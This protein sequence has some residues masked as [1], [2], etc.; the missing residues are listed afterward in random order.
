[1]RVALMLLLVMVLASAVFAAEDIE[2]LRKMYSYDAKEALDVRET[3]LFEEDKVKV[4]DVTYASPKGGRVSAYLVVPVGKGP[5]AGIVFG[6]WG[7]GNRTEFLAEAVRYGKAGAVCLMI[8]YPWVR[9]A[10]WR[11]RLKQIGDPERDHAIWVQTVIDLQRGLD[12]LEARADVDPA[13]L[14]YV[15]HS[16]GAQWGAILSAIEPRLKGVVIMAGVPDQASIWRDSD[17]PGIVEYRARAPKDKQEEYLRVSEKTAAIRYVPHAR[18]PV[19]FQFA[20]FERYFN[21]EAMERYAAAAPAGKEVRWYNTGH[22]LNDPQALIDR[23]KWLR[24]KLGMG[25]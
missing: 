22:E 4:L 17:E 19:L 12:L 16:W 14:G 1:M 2:D 8:D 21:R 24:G 10:E 20:K 23:E 15:G 5:F 25:G 18:C 9:P 7:E 11:R 13:R 3:L 6:H